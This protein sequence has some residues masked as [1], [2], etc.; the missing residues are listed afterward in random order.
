MSL[1]SKLSS[2]V[3]SL[4]TKILKPELKVAKHFQQARLFL[5]PL[6]IWI[7]PSRLFLWAYTSGVFPLS[8]MMCRTKGWGRR[9]WSSSP[10][11]LNSFFLHSRSVCLTSRFSVPRLKYVMLFVFWSYQLSIQSN[12]LQWNSGLEL[13]RDVSGWNVAESRC[14]AIKDWGYQRTVHSGK[15]RMA[16]RSGRK[17]LTKNGKKSMWREVT[18]P[19]HTTQNQSKLQN[20][21]KKRRY[22]QDL[23]VLIVWSSP[24]NMKQRVFSLK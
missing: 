17:T 11:K 10:V 4:L 5:S 9:M 16:R 2:Q 15:R 21:R 7:L 3:T 23:T 14:E 22:R 19:Q 20:L 24:R 1:E 13:T 18:P 8:V 6:T 12:L